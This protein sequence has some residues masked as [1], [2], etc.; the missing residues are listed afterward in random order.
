MVFL[1]VD[2]VCVTDLYPPGA[3]Y[4]AVEKSGAMDD[5]C[6]VSAE[7]PHVVPHIF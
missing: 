6:N 7:T 2:L 4:L 1:D 3:L 5:V